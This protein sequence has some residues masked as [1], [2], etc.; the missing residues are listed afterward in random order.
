M[1]SSISHAREGQ[2]YLMV[3]GD[4]DAYQKCQKL[5]EDLSIKTAVYRRWRRS[6]RPL[7]QAGEY[8]HEYQYGWSR[9]RAG[10]R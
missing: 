7:S 6:Q 10:A 1:A 4:T 3:S 5:L 2:L 9:G 8:G